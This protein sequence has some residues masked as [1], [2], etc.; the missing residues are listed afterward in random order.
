MSRLDEIP[1]LTLSRVF[2]LCAVPEI[3]G[4][5]RA[6]RYM[7]IYAMLPWRIELSTTLMAIFS[8]VND[9]RKATFFKRKRI[10]FFKSNIFSN[11]DSGCSA[12]VGWS[13]DHHWVRQDTMRTE[14]DMRHSARYAIFRHRLRPVQR[15]HPRGLRQSFP[16]ARIRT[17]R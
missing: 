6:L 13:A 15:L 11:C 9:S 10:F 2:I 17:N 16:A 7:C 5:A 4:C 3:P 1:K 12:T 8:S 14:R